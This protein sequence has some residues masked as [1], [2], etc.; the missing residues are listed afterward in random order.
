MKKISII[1]AVL[2][3]VMVFVFA[4]CGGEKV[5]GKKQEAPAE[6]YTFNYAVNSTSVKIQNQYSETIDHWSPIALWEIT[7]NYVII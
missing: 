1:L 5:E 4:G 7:I 3:L 2:S 6:A